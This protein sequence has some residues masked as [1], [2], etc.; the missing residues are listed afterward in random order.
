MEGRPIA[1]N[2]DTLRHPAVVIGCYTLVAGCI[3]MTM[4]LLGGT[5]CEWISYDAQRFHAMAEAILAGLT[6][7]IAYSDPK[8]PLLFFTVA[9]MDALAP[10]GTLDVPLMTGLNIGAATL[11]FFIGREVYGWISGVTAGLIYLVAAVFVEGYFLFSEQFCVFFLLGAYIAARDGQGAAAGLLAGLAMGFKQYAVL[12]VIPLIYLMGKRDAKAV[13]PFFATFAAMAAIPFLL[14]F[15]IYGPEALEA[16]LLWT[17]GIAP[18]YLSGGVADLPAYQPTNLLSFAANL[19]LSVM[20]VLPVGVFAVANIAQRG[21]KT[22][23]EQAIAL[24]SAVFFLTIFI[25]QY[26][27]YWILVLPFLSLLACG[28]FADRKE[29]ST[30]AGHCER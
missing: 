6:P 30:A 11:L 25:R 15:A 12:G 9:A 20:F 22:R 4:A 28:A 19:L 17:F 10:A 13:W 21:L 2:R 16:A 27:H 26:L 29:P 3:G 5:G 23:Q 18:L 8:P 7:Y 14:L 1:L 24:F